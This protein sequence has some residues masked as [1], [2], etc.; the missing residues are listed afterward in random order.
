MSTKILRTVGFLEGV[1]SIALFFVAM[2]MKYMFDNPSL[3]FPTG[4]THGILF[5]LFLLTLLITSHKKAW[6]MVWFLLG[7]VAAII[8]CGTFVFDH[9]IKKLDEA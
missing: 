7:L 2:P 6:S 3:I 4:M 5:L 1:S 9:K 8:P